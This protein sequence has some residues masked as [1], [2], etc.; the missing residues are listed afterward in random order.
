VTVREFRRFMKATAH[1][2]AAERGPQL[3]DYPDADREHTSR[4]EMLPLSRSSD[5]VTLTDLRRTP[6]TGVRRV[7]LA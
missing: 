5:L 3:S 4:R 2:S 1:V 6:G 7:T